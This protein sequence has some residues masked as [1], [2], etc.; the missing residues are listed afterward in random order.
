MEKVMIIKS[1]AWIKS[2]GIFYYDFA[3]VPYDVKMEGVVYRVFSGRM[4][5]GSLY[6]FYFEENLF[7][8]LRDVTDKSNPKDIYHSDIVELDGKIYYISF[9]NGSFCMTQK[10]TNSIYHFTF[11]EFDGEE[12]KR[13]KI[14][15]NLYENPELIEASK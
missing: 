5:K 3:K 1:R 15:G 13:I 10:F 6:E 2:K 9:D 8:G 4:D 7:T 12:K 14:I 11:S